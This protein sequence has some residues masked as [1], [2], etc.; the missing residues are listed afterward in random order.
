[1]TKYDGIKPYPKEVL[2]LL[3]KKGFD[4]KWSV[5]CNTEKNYEDAYEK[6]EQLHKFYFGQ[7]KYKNYESYRISKRKR[8]IK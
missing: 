3:S 8:R 5:Y 2:D 7:R 4:R 1:M 6:V